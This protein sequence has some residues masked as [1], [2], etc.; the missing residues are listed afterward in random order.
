MN[1]INSIGTANPI[2]E[3]AIERGIEILQRIHFEDF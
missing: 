3:K 2:Y 1:K